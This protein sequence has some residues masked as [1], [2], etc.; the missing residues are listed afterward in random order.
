MKNLSKN[1]I[2][3]AACTVLGV[4]IIFYFIYQVVQMNASP[5]K[6]EVALERDVQNTIITKAKCLRLSKQT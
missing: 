4:L 1:T 6:T 2:K 3:Y 5:Y